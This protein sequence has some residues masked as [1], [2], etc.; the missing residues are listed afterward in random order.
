MSVAGYVGPALVVIGLE[1]LLLL[2]LWRHRVAGTRAQHRLEDRLRF[3]TLLADLSAALIHVA[4]RGLDAA[5]GHALQQVVTFLGTDRGNLDEY[6]DGASAT[7]IAWTAPGMQ[8]L[9]SILFGGRFAWTADVLARGEIVRFSR[10]QDLPASASA[11]RLS[12]E[13][14][15]TRSH[16]SIPLRAGGSLLGVLSFDCVRAERDWPDELVGRLRLLS[17]AFASALQRKRMELSLAERLR[18]QRLL[19][20]LSARFGTVSDLDLDQEIHDAIRAIADFLDVDRVT[21]LEFAERGDRGCSWTLREPMDP[22][23]FPWLIASVRAGTAVRLSR[24]ADVPAAAEEDRRSGHALGIVSQVAVPLRAAGTVVGGLVIATD[25]RERVWTDELVEQLHLLGEVVANALAGAKAGRESAR[26]RQELAHIGRV[27]ALG[28]LAASLAHE[29]NQPLTA[30]RNNAYVARECLESE[31]INV[32]SLREIM[33]DIQA[34][35]RRAAGVIQRLRALLKKG[36]LEHAALDI[37]DVVS[38]VAHLVWSDAVARN[39]SMSLELGS[40]LP[41]VRGDRGQLQ[42]VVLNMVQNGLEAM[43][44]QDGGPHALVIR[45][46]A[47]PAGVMVAV[48]DSGAGIGDGDVERL[49]QPLYTTKAD[50]LGMGLAIARTIVDA[51][52]GELAASN[53]LGGGATFRFTLPTEAARSA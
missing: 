5:L 20:H 7:R 30:I 1:T 19:S 29:L 21:L 10:V 31:V 23:R 11:D 32:A 33:T 43:S 22:D 16:L 51:H 14:L 46:S 24:P 52:G 15:G 39:V 8:A 28:E 53:N 37:N 3:E 18:F 27:S 48:Q 47:P 49:F 35:D 34:D 13:R 42:Q 45:T 40:Q 25:V 36:T 38:E 50:G 41:R 12:Y 26:L 9:P 2:W 6:V 17:E 44:E 4:A